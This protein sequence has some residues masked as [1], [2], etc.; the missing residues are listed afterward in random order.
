MQSPR[1]G[2]IIIT[3]WIIVKEPKN[4]SQ[5]ST[6]PPTL[7]QHNIYIG[8]QIHK[9]LGWDSIQQNSRFCLSRALCRAQAR[10][11]TPSE[12]VFPGPCVGMWSTGLP[13][14]TWSK[15]WT[16]PKIQ[17]VSHFPSHGLWWRGLVSTS[18]GIKWPNGTLSS[19]DFE[20]FTVE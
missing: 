12:D 9:N 5:V 3:S 15:G 7:P 11:L 14:A 8:F 10:D 19:A 13:E 17:P 4:K 16:W 1:L 20:E 2:Y 18:K 6:G